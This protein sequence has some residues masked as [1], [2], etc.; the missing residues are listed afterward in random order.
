VADDHY[1]GLRPVPQIQKELFDAAIHLFVCLSLAAILRRAGLR[2]RV[3][4]YERKVDMREV[5]LT[6]ILISQA[7]AYLLCKMTILKLLRITCSSVTF[8][9]WS[10]GFLPKRSRRGS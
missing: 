4:F 6:R 8:L 5:F 2:I 9:R 7:L 1:F 10:Q 3:G